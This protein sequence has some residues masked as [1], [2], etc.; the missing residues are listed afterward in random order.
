MTAGSEPGFDLVDHPLGRPLGYP[1]T[2][3][4]TSGVLVEN[5]FYELRPAPDGGVGDSQVSAPQPVPLDDLLRGADVA[6]VAGRAAV[7]AI[8]S[9]ASPAQ[10]LQKFTTR[11]VS[12]VVPMTLATVSG[13]GRGYSAHVSRAGYVPMT[14]IDVPDRRSPFFVL[15]LD[16][17]Q[18]GALDQTEP[19]Y[20]RVALPAAH[21]PTLE[22]DERLTDVSLYVSRWGHLLSTDGG[23]LQP[24]PTSASPQRALLEDLLGRSPE[25]RAL[26]GPGPEA[27]VSRAAASPALRDE[28]RRCFQRNGW[29]S[30]ERSVR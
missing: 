11:G 25:L 21:R 20:E 15:W 28:I 4:R 24:A 29:V 10:L 18:L 26:A 19:N 12:S 22:S 2:A 27:F 16:P 1:G 30:A 13:L 3:P 9:N 6:T 7:L 14:P 5:V 17:A 23:P 8:G